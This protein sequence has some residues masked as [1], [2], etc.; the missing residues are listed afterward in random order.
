M[1]M[2]RQI[3]F[4]CSL[5]LLALA[6]A[7]AQDFVNRE[8]WHT[9]NIY[10]KNGDTM[11]GVIRY[12]MDEQYVMLKEEETLKTYSVNQVESFEL[13]DAEHG[14]FRWFYAL[15]VRDNRRGK[16]LF[17]EMLVDGSKVLLCREDWVLRRPVGRS[18]MAWEAI[19][20]RADSFYLFDRA[21]Q[22]LVPLLG[23]RKELLEHLSDH[24]DAVEQFIRERQL[25][26]QS[27]ADLLRLFYY[28]GKL[29]EGQDYKGM[30][31]FAI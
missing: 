4:T 26:L 11:K 31:E 18:N 3:V 6:G 29:K 8:V 30:P 27:R 25:D 19:Q 17:F 14:V 7:K 10:L 24:R 5:V 28:Y 20:V 12:D 13:L 22:T 1:I 21:T 23:S 15:P 9:G 2:N 16:E